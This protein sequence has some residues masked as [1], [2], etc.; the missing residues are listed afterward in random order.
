MPTTKK[1][2]VRRPVN[3]MSQ[4]TN[5][6]VGEVFTLAEAAAYLRLSEAEVLRMVRVQRLPARQFGEEWRF[7]RSAIQAWLSA[8]LAA[9]KN[10]GIWAAAGA[11]SDDPYLDEMLAGIDRMRGRPT[12][13][14]G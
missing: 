1:K 7:L 5:G 11:I 14:E 12:N 4:A 8:P 9:Q 6:P 3:A 13:Q 2:P 10:Q